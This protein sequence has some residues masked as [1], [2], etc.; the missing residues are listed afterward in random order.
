MLFFFRSIRR[1]LISMSAFRKYFLYAVGE[2]LLVMIGILLALQVNNWN[3][4]RIN[5]NREVK[6]LQGLRS[7]LETNAE[8]LKKDI[9]DDRRYFN[10]CKIVVHH[11]D[12]RLPYHDSLDIHLELSQFSADIVLATSAF[13]AIRSIGFDIISDDSLRDGIIHLFDTEYSTMVRNTRGLEDQFWPSIV[14]P[15]SNRHLRIHALERREAGYFPTDYEALMD[16]VE[17]VS[18]IEKRAVFR[19]EAVMQKTQSLDLTLD[20]INWIDRELH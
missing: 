6:L 9:E 17:F 1:T 12:S 10:S 19:W 11:L 14:L 8:R 18:M 5:R 16:D 15:V 2:I 13:E 3:E 20:L 7:N 4:S